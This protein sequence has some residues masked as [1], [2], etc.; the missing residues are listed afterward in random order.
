M[1]SLRTLALGGIAFDLRG[2]VGDPVKSGARFPLHAKKND[3]L[4]HHGG[5]ALRIAVETPH[6]N[7]IKIGDPVTFRGE[8]VGRV[9]SQALHADGRSIGVRL[10][11]YSPYQGLVRTNSVF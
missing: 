9:A 2:E 4:G 6:L 8:T 3:A 10:D 5:V 7:G 11:I 1:E